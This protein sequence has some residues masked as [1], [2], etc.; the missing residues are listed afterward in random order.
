M[1]IKAKNGKLVGRPTSS[2]K[3]EKTPEELIGEGF[4]DREAVE[5]PEKDDDL[6]EEEGVEKENP[7]ELIMVL[8]PRVTYKEVQKLATKYNRSIG[9]TINYALKLLDETIEKQKEDK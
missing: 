5:F 7:D 9:E 3:T 2:S 4:R 1:S 6:E 8:F